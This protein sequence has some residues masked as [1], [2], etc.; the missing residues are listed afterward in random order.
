MAGQNHEGVKRVAYCVF[1]IWEEGDRMGVWNSSRQSG[2][3]S[4]AERVLSEFS[5]CFL[6]C[7][8]FMY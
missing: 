8:Y 1:R 2:F 6:Y 5:W 4:E 7:L 3:S